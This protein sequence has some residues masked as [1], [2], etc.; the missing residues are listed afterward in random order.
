MDQSLTL[1]RESERERVM[2]LKTD[3]RDY[4]SY[5]LSDYPRHKACLDI[6]TMLGIN[7]VT[8]ET[9][10]HVDSIL[11]AVMNSSTRVRLREIFRVFHMRD[12]L[13]VDLSNMDDGA[14]DKKIKRIMR[15]VSS[16]LKDM[17]GLQLAKRGEYYITQKLHPF[18]IRKEIDVD[19]VI[20]PQIRWENAFA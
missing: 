14:R 20:Y 18:R 15:G 3:A 5:C 4:E 1:Y 2:T 13:S 8:T 10:V 6:M 17:Y 9:R 11:E 16:I 12:E 19:E 7:N